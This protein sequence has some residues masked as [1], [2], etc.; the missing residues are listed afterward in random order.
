MPFLAVMHDVWRHAWRARI[1]V[2]LLGLLALILSALPALMA[3]DGSPEGK[4]KLF[5]HYALYCQ[6]FVLWSAGALWLIWIEGKER[7]RRVHWMLALTPVG[8]LRV[9][10]GKCAATFLMVLLG[11]LLT[12]A[13][14]AASAGALLRREAGAEALEVG[15]RLEEVQHKIPLEAAEVRVEEVRLKGRPERAQVLA[16]AQPL[17]FR[18]APPPAQRELRLEG[19][20]HSASSSDGTLLRIEIE[21]GGHVLFRRVLPVTAGEPFREILPQA[22]A[23][24]DAAVVLTQ[25]NPEDKIFYIKAGDPLRLSLPYGSLP[26]NLV[27]AALLFSLMGLYAVLLAG[28][29]GQFLSTQAGVLVAGSITLLSLFKSSVHTMLFPDRAGLPPQA[30]DPVGLLYAVVWKPL[31]ALLPDL[32]AL[33]PTARLVAGEWITLGDLALAALSLLPML[34]AMFVLLALRLPRQEPGA[35][36]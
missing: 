4:L 11:A 14:I 6:S 8:R 32:G 13:G 20:L 10:L 15:R 1:P 31:L 36:G 12:T 23:S 21:S 25:I 7:R 34:L 30:F 17:R 16:P 35:L 9:V 5:L 18:F 24:S 26:A 22:I 3:S 29:C 2:A 27:R 28:T 33:D 19:T